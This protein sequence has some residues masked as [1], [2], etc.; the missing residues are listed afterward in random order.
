MYKRKLLP[1]EPDQKEQYQFTY[2]LNNLK[3]ARIPNQKELFQKTWDYYLKEEK[4]FL[5]LLKVIYFQ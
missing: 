2:N 4:K 1:R 3:K 5:M